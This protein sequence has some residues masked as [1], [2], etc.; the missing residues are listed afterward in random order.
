MQCGYKVTAGQQCPEPANI[1]HLVRVYDT[2]FEPGSETRDAVLMLCTK[3]DWTPDVPL[4]RSA[5]G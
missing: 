4:A 5:E 3:H 2:P 1:A